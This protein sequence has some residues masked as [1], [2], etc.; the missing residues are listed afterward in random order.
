MDSNFQKLRAAITAARTPI[1]FTSMCL[2]VWAFSYG[3]LLCD[4]V[5]FCTQDSTR[6]VSMAQTMPPEGN[7]LGYGD[8]TAKAHTSSHAEGGRPPWESENG[9]IDAQEK[10]HLKICNYRFTNI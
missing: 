3:T 7:C 4:L 6:A 2:V 10:G 1:S 5:A 9:E 8:D